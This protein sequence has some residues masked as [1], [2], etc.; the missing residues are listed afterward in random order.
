MINETCACCKQ[1]FITSL[2]LTHLY[3]YDFLKITQIIKLDLYAFIK[4]VSIFSFQP[5][6]FQQHFSNPVKAATF[7]KFTMKPINW[8]LVKRLDNKD[9]EGFLF[10]LFYSQTWEDFSKKNVMTQFCHMIWIFWL[11]IECILLKTFDILITN[12]LCNGLPPNWYKLTQ[13]NHIGRIVTTVALLFFFKTKK[14]VFL[15]FF[16]ILLAFFLMM[17]DIH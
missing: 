17:E 1:W 7:A 15:V 8:I 3:L 10:V 4:L 12:R 11:L 5:L 14:I 2:S 13:I 16:N 6:I 9:F